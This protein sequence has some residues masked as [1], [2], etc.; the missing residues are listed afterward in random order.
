MRQVSHLTQEQIRRIFPQAS[1]SLIAANQGA[2]SSLADLVAPV[3]QTEAPQ[4]KADGIR[5]RGQM[6]KTEASFARL[7]ESRRSR[8]EIRDFEFEAVKLHLGEGAYY[9]L[10]FLVRENDDRVTLV[11]IKGAKI[12]SRD[13]V[14]FKVAVGKYSWLYR[15]ELWQR[16]S[17]EWSQLFE[18]EGGSL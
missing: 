6:N 4:K 8:G 17:G 13:S 14:R 7:L 5:R 1:T 3:V 9:T 18:Q 11:E 12:W 15:F 10:D 2:V 16:A